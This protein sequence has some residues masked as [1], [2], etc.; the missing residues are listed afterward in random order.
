MGR[1]PEETIEQVLAATDIV[2]LVGSYLPLKRSGS[3]F[4]TNCPFHNEKTP[5]FHVNPAR[6]SYHCFG[7]GAGGSA[8]GFV[9]A[10]E[11]LP[12]VEATQRLAARSGII[13]QEDVYDPEAEKRRKNRSKLIEVNNDCLLYTSP[14]PR[15]LSTSRM[16]SS[17]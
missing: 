17:A 6:Q 1:I 9:M 7:C 15:D 5:S 8:I 11:N 14:S 3:S 13:I 4:T 10:Y 12:F 16:P 2:D